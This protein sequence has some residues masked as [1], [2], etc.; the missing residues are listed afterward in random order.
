MIDNNLIN[1]SKDG[2]GTERPAVVFLHGWRS[3]K[4]VWQ[5]I[6]G[7][8]GQTGRTIYRLDLPGFGNSPAPQ[9]GFTISDYAALVA[10][11]IKKQNLNKVVLIGHS[12]GG[13]IGIKLAATAPDVVEKLVLADS[14]GFAMKSA[15]KSGYGLAAK[16]VK[17]FF[18]PSFMQGLRKRIYKLI[19]AEDYL[20]T[21][22]LQKTFVN[23]VSEDLSE[24]MKKI[25]SPTLI[26][27]GE[28]DMDTPKE[29]G[30]R[31][32]GLILNSRLEVLEGA[33]H[34][35]FLDK[36]DEFARFLTEFVSQ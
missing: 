15:K 21:P 26:V 22:A 34:F 17:P 30:S 24:D 1:Y 23:A 35:S 6:I 5:G 12:F 31:M 36:P 28:K 11:F 18:K 29:F 20:A 8:L 16:L 13:R 10:G 4:E 2:S 14:A 3:S 19:G 27:F 32:R 25:V 33:G 7:K 9:R